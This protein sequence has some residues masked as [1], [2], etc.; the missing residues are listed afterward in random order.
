MNFNYSNPYLSTRLPVFARNV[1]STSHPL[2][3]QAGLRMLYNGGNAVDAAVAAAAAMTICEPVSNGLGSDSFCILW[4]GKE[5]H[6]LNASGRA[7]AA[8]TPEYF[9][10]KYGQDVATPPKRGFDAVTVPGAVSS[11]VAMSERFGKLPFADL[12]QP[13]IEIAERGY[14]LPVVVQQKW[15]AATP[16]LQSLPGFAQ[17][18]MPWGRAPEVGELF[19]FKAAAR[20]LRAIAQTRGQAYYGGEIAQA[21][22]RFSATHGGNLMA[23]DFAAY[24]PEWVKPI[25][26]DYRGY[27][28]HEIPP[29]GQGIAALIALGILG[30]FDVAGLPVDGVDSQ[31]LQIEAM[32][33]AFADVYRFVAEPSS[34]EVSVDQML[35]DAYLASRAKLIDLKKA[36]DFGAGNPVKGGTI[37]LTAADENG[38]MVSFI[39]SNYMG[40]GSGCVEPTFRHQPAEPG[41]WLQRG[42]EGR[43]PGQSGGAGQAAVPYHHPGLPHEGRP[44]GDELRR[45]GRQHAAPGPH[46]DPGAHARLRAEPAG[47][48]RCA[49]LALQ[50]RAGDQRG[51]GAGCAD[52]ARPGRA[53]A[54]HGSHQRLLPGLW[55]R[56]VH[57]ARGRPEGR[58]LCGRQRR[59][60]R[61]AGGW[62]LTGLHA[63]H[64]VCCAVRA[65]AAGAGPSC[66]PDVRRHIVSRGTQ[67]LGGPALLG[68]ARR[69]G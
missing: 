43:Q 50:R 28:L 23:S 69:C 41:P 30:H 61:R 51:V 22:E 15:A 47:R 63:C 16:E 19:Q 64:F 35:D 39:Q 37:Y 20:G 32:K 8:W 7:P 11:W 4:D 68:A 42:C 2:A 62:L 29:N 65:S 53:R 25:A 5:L 48:L 45:D 49:A 6:G 26:K 54:P 9:R 24:Q 18:F 10:R 40:F 1:V 60:P 14:L 58:G 52:R 67:P 34:M 21:I 56:P 33:L 55:R 66:R 57:L 36:Q 38:M 3:A 46:A 13:A 17:A 12:M 59:A 27:T 44:A 31:H